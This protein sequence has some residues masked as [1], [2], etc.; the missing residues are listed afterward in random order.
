MAGWIFSAFADE[1][2]EHIDQQILALQKAGMK[3]I[4]LRN[5]NGHNISVLPLDLARQVKQ[6][7]DAAGIQVGMYGSPIGKIDIT[8]DAE[9]DYAK[10]R[11]IG[12]LSKILAAKHVRIFSYFNKHKAPHETW[13]KE[14]LARLSKLVR[15][16]GQSGLVLYHENEKDVFGE[17]LADVQTLRDEIHLKHPDQFRMI[18]DSDNYNQA[19][20]DVW[21]NWLE[22]RQTTGAIH[23]KDSQ[24]LADGSF[25]HVPAGEGDG[26]YRRI[27][28]DCAKR[29]WN[30]PITLEP[31]LARSKAVLATGPHG[32]ANE[33]LAD[34]ST[35][36]VF[37]I[38]AAAGKKLLAEAGKL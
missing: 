2:A 34:L 33:K 12:E 4:D 25:Q 38:A 10:L 8:D 1:A 19:G 3:H 14:S 9:I 30:G 6:K 23:F 20:N 13:R 21:T 35:M 5:V 32:K 26:C 22:L 37:Q 17:Q 15:I 28:E 31:H 16:A 36:E 11:H 18:F 24:K 27:V 29:G 7:L